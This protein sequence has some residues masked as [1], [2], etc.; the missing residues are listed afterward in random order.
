MTYLVPYD[1]SALSQASLVRARAYATAVNEAPSQ[2][3]DEL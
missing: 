2:V 1:G 3:R